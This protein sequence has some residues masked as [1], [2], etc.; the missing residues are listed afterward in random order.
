MAEA[1]RS[2]PL[3]SLEKELSCSICTDVL[4]QPL[5]L[6]D[7][8]HTFC[9][10]CLKEWFSWQ[11]QSATSLHPYTC[12]SCRASVRATQPNATVTTLLDMFLQTNPGRG[13]TER[14]KDDMRKVYKPGDNVMPK[15]R[16]RQD[17]SDEEDRR[18]MD[19]VRLLSLEDAGVGNSSTLSPPP[20]RRRRLRSH[21]QSRERSQDRDRRRRERDGSRAAQLG[22]TE[23]PRSPPPPRHVEHQSSLRSL[24]SASDIDT[25]EMEDEIMRQIREEGLLDG[26][27]LDNIDVSQEEEITE[28]IAEAFRRRQR[29]RDR[30]RAR[31]HRSRSATPSSSAAGSA[32]HHSEGEERPQRRPRPRAES[33]AT[34]EAMA[35][36][37]SSQSQA[38]RPPASRPHLFDAV[39]QGTRHRRRSSSQ[40]DRSSSRRNHHRQL[41]SVEATAQRPAARSATDLSNRPQT[42][43]GASVVER[44]RRPS[45]DDR[46]ATDPQGGHT[47]VIPNRSHEPSPRRAGFLPDATRPHLSPSQAASPHAPPRRMSDL[48]AA[49]RPARPTN[50]SSSSL[51]RARNSADIPRSRPSSSDASARHSTLYSEPFVSCQSCKTIGIQYDL[52]YTCERCHAD[53]GAK[54]SI[55]LR[56]YRSGAGCKHWFGFGSAA[57]AKYEQRAPP[58]GY[59]P[60]Y[61]QPHILSGQRYLRPSRPAW[62]DPQSRL[63]DEDPSKRFQSGVFCD[64]CIA[65]ANGCYWKCNVCNEGAWGFCNDCVNQGRHCTHPLL[66]L[67]HGASASSRSN[68]TSPP[69]TANTP[70]ITPKSAS[71]IRGPGTVP[72]ANKLFRPLTFS[73]DCDRCTYPIP[74][75]HT[76]FHCP[77][78]Y[79]GNS[80]ICNSCYHGLVTSGAVSHENGPN[81]WRRCP[82]GHRMVVVGFE[83][84]DAGQ[85]RIVTRDLVGGFALRDDDTPASPGGSSMAVTTR[86]SL[87]GTVASARG[88]TPSW[89]W[90]DTDGTVRKARPRAAAAAAAAAA[91]TAGISSATLSRTSS[92]GSASSS[93]AVPTLATTA[94]TAATGAIP[95]STSSSSST[96]ATSTLPAPTSTSAPSIPPKHPHHHQPQAFPPDGGLG[97][98]AVAL[99]SYYPA[100]HVRDE[101]AFPKGAEI[102]EAEDINGDWFWG[103][104]AGAKGLFPGA[105]VR[106]L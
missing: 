32:V 78:C 47:F 18:L 24:L 58:G 35:E 41:S 95:P 104:Y 19:Q 31:H 28:R 97:L 100:P 106:V 56:C 75:S 54:Y 3:E 66:P 13:K 70:T 79:A 94:A 37:N 82:R 83:D 52:H 76:R 5:T 15:L 60:G 8:L 4:Y 69:S 53:D 7:C 38:S 1:S 40:E 20:D 45:Q 6:L 57:W 98:R 63:T 16:R 88:S 43:Q 39:N 48:G 11:A 77:R 84:R 36:R 96:D 51:S 34:R 89:S 73:T 30:A 44:R 2:G 103:V 102:R 9:G 85:R 61:E 67:H 21:E 81:G 80:D 59:R 27:D 65:F 62:G 71:L 72:L 23:S 26:I 99:W 90:R 74:P 92:G 68:P 50:D 33:A 87:D 91:A 46:R 14:E 64:A 49:A 12:P 105:Y 101:L 25:Q 22:S 86:S 29:D 93:T 42:V 55:C 17:S 10:A